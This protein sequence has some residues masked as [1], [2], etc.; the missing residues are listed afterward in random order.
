MRILFVF[1]HPDDESFGPAGTIKRLVGLGYTVRVH[2]LCCGTR[3]GAEHVASARR[4]AFREACDILGVT[5]S[6]GESNDVA[7]SYHT[8]V[9]EIAGI[10]AEFS[11]SAVYTH[12]ISD[13]HVDH[14]ITAE[15]CLVACRPKPDSV[16]ERL[17]MCE[18]ASSTGWAFNQVTPVFE[19]TVYYDVTEQISLKRMLFDLYPS[20]TYAYPDARSVESMEALAMHRGTQIGVP[21]A[22]AFK[23]VFSRI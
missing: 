18:I 15:A 3:P 1:A 17:L 22:E 14:R 6:I 13:I 20:E 10:I 16:V 2:S 12:N 21:F 11:P 5:G 7:L 4:Q 19:P 23:L 8:A 9:A